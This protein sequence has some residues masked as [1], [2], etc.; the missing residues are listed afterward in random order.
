MVFDAPTLGELADR[1]VEQE[2]ESA[3]DDLLEEMLREM[4]GQV[5]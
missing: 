3:D 5:R 1:I 4:E 2:L